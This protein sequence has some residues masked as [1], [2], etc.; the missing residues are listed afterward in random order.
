MSGNADKE[1][2]R[3]LLL[4]GCFISDG[5]QR[6]GGMHITFYQTACFGKDSMFCSAH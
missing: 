3:E 5:M 1:C 6:C 2:K 4:D